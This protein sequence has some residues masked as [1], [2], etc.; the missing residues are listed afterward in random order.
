MDVVSQIYDGLFRFEKGKDNQGRG[1]PIHK[2]LQF[3]DG[4]VQDI[5]EWLLAEFDWSGCGE[6][7]DA[8]CGVGYG[9]LLLARHTQAQ[10]TG[11]SISAA[12]IQQ[13]EANARQQGLGH[14]THFQQ[15]SFEEAP[16]KTYDAIIAVES[17]KHSLLLGTSLKSLSR[18]LKRGGRLFI[19]EDFYEGARKGRL[20]GQYAADWALEAAYRVED[21]TPALP[22][23]QY[24]DLTH[25]M[26]SK[27]RAS[28]WAKQCLLTVMARLH[29]RR[30]FNVYRVF[31]GGIY[32][33]RLYA[34]Q[35]MK[36]GCLVYQ[37][38]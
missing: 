38:Q 20:A 34:R 21:Y 36:Y 4:E 29:T 9:S 7:L 13:A 14:R 17:L 33:D 32:L 11:I 6:I 23:A 2:R 15:A 19:V 37:K 16:R 5:Y 26:P 18:Q 35:E 10:I 3:E 1:Y 8:G 28:L 24:R 27:N 30:P 12:E 22:D 31:R 25:L